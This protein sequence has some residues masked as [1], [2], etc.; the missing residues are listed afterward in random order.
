MKYKGMEVT[1]ANGADYPLSSTPK[2]MLVWYD[3][4]ITPIVADV[5]GYY[6]GYW[7]AADDADKGV[8]SYGHAAEIPQAE[9]KLLTNR[10]I[11]RWL[12]QGNG[13][14]CATE[15]DKA[16][17]ANIGWWYEKGYEDEAV[18]NILIRKLSDSEWHRPTREY[19]FG[20]EVAE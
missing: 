4:A 5:L 2:K 7:L 17:R 10:E 15:G 6:N 1:E 18:T 19:A 9:E 14:W 3:G 13:E 12:A 11:S 16:N 8:V 20:E